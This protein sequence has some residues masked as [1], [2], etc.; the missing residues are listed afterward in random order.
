M[1][2]IYVKL[3]KEKSDYYY[4]LTVSIRMLLTETHHIFSRPDCD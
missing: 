2:M 4:A 3:G 1:S